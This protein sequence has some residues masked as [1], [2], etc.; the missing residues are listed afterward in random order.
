MAD[1]GADLIALN[2]AFAAAEFAADADFFKRHLADHL[3][4][5][6]ASGARADKTTFLN[7]LGTPG[8][9]NEHLEAGDIEV[10]LFGGDLALCSLV[11]RFKGVRGG[12]HVDGAFRNTRVFTKIDG[13]WK[14]ALW[15]NT[16]EPRAQ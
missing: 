6:R 10:L 15:F 3:Q 16:T 9:T 11:V 2:K 12:K 5:R 1:A 4:F 13:I 14:C 8:N 7:D